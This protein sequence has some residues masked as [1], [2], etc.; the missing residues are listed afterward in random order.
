MCCSN[1]FGAAATDVA[2]LPVL[3]VKDSDENQLLLVLPSAAVEAAVDDSTTTEDDDAV[4]CH[5]CKVGAR[6]IGA[7]VRYA[8]V[9]VNGRVVVVLVDLDS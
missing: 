8:I 9:G 6:A 1:D 4:V 7:V 3:F 5:R 2:V